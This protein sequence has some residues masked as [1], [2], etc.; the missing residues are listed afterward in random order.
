MAFYQS[1]ML[2]PV[3]LGITL[4]LW[5]MQ[6]S[7]Y[8]K[9]SQREQERWTERKRQQSYR[10]QEYLRRVAR[11]LDRERAAVMT[12]AAIRS[13]ASNVPV[14]QRDTPAPVVVYG[15]SQVYDI[16]FILHS[17]LVRLQTR[18]QSAAP[19]VLL[20]SQN[21]KRCCQGVQRDL[22]RTLPV[23]I[24]RPVQGPRACI[25]L[26][27]VCT[28]ALLLPMRCSALSHS[29]ASPYCLTNWP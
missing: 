19:K 17:R 29:S 7:S 23:K 2:M 15:Y 26:E 25:V 20:H 1:K 11:H 13:A 5:W 14:L 28:W 6:R 8:K 12:F 4:V 22:R 16:F 3:V 24:R 10:E 27:C 9:Q 21:A 18:I